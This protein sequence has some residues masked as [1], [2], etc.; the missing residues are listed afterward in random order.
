MPSAL[1]AASSY[2]AAESGTPPPAAHKLAGGDA[3]AP[4]LAECLGTFALVFTMGCC[5]LAPGSATWNST[6]VACAFAVLLYSTQPVAGGCLNPAVSFSLGLIGHLRWPAVIRYWLVQTAAAVA[7]GACLQ[8]IFAPCPNKVA[9]VFPFSWEYAVTAEVIYTFM[10]C[11]V[12][13]NCAASKRNNPKDDGNQFAALAV[14]LVLVAG[15]YAVGDISGAILNPAAA[16][17]LSTA[18]GDF[19]WA[20]SWLAAELI[21]GALAAIMFRAVRPEEYNPPEGG[22]RADYEPRLHVRCASEFLGTF[23]LVLTF[24]LNIVQLSPAQAFSSAAALTCMMYSLGNVSGAHFNPAVTLGVV[25][26][27]RDKCSPADGA[28]YAVC[29]ILGGAC[30][31][32]V[33]AQYHASGPH[34]RLTFGLRPGAGYGPNAA[35]VVELFFAGV[36]AYSF[37]ACTTTAIPASWRTRWSFYAALTIGSCM[38]AGGVSIG[39]ISGGEL[40]PAVSMGVSV[41][42]LAYHGV[43][44][45]TSFT[46]GAILSV[47][48]LTGGLLAAI[49]FRLTHPDEYKKAPLLA[50]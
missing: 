21:G 26:S 4:Y 34:A 14:G 10:V 49:V 3:A 17:G 31:G 36:L 13:N 32:T 24:G 8:A 11:F 16:L 37:L 2:G 20:F 1:S 45:P 33:Y 25:L 23:L 29:Q 7:A 22:M 35:G 48:E 12:V 19:R 28:A 38:T 9:P 44:E 46:A 27:G 18:A 39:S 15:G 47:W 43:R 42:N 6:A 30:A 5:M 40:N 50:K 41:A